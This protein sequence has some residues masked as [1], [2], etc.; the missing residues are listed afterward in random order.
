VILRRYRPLI[1]LAVQSTQAAT[2]LGSAF[3]YYPVW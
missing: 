1:R 3:C 2:A